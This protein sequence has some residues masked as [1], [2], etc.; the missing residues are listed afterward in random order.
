MIAPHV[1]SCYSG[2]NSEEQRECVNIL[3]QLSN[4]ETDVLKQT[5]F[6]YLIPGIG[7]PIRFSFQPVCF[8]IA[9]GFLFQ[10]EPSC[11]GIFQYV[12]FRMLRQQCKQRLIGVQCQIVV[13]V[14]KGKVIA[15]CDIYTSIA[16]T[17]QTF[18]L[19]MD[20]FDASIFLCP[21]IA[22]LRAMVW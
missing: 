14:H 5:P 22:Q 7:M 8:H 21:L 19:L 1:G 20:Y 9:I 11:Y 2:S 17:T 10:R 15:L 4:R 18:I 3:K 12:I 13:T 16:S 6:V